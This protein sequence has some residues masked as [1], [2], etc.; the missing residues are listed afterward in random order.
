M[1]LTRNPFNKRSVLV[2]WFVSYVSVLLVPMLISGLI[3]TATWHVVEAEVNRSN[4][5]ILGQTEQ[6]IDNSLLGIERLSIEIALN[7]RVAGFM[8][9]TL[10]LTDSDR[11]DLFNIVNDLR[12]YKVA[13]DYIEQIFVYY[14]NSDTVL[15]TREHMD[16]R[17]LYRSVR[18]SEDKSY[19][20]WKAF[21]DKRYMKEY[22]PMQYGDGEQVE[23]AIV[24]AKSATLDN[25]DQSGA[26]I[27]IVIKDSKLLGS[28]MPAPNASLAILDSQNRLVASKGLV[29]SPAF[30]TY[31]RLVDAKGLFYE[32]DNGN[33]LALSY[34]TSEITGWK[35]VSII[36]AELFDDKMLYLKKLII[37]SLVLCILIGGLVAYIYLRRNYTPISLLIRSFSLKS[38]V[39][40]DEGSNEYL[41][42]QAAL[43][44][45]FD[46]KEKID[47]RLMQHS[48]VIRASFLQGLL[49]GRLDH[50]I[51]LHE[52]LAAHDLRIVSTDF[53]VL[54]F[55]IET[56][57]K[58]QAEGTA[59]PRKIK[60]LHFII[61][62]VA[63]D[64]AGEQHQAF[65]TEMDNMSV[66]IVN[67][68]SQP[69]EI[70][71]K[72]M[73]ER[74]QSFLFDHFHVHLTVSISGIHH[75]LYAIPTAYQE[76]LEAMEYRMVM[77]SGEIIRYAEL[78]IPRA[79][80]EP[81]SYYY[82]LHVE[83]Q[84]INFVKI[85]D[86][87]RSRELI[88]EIIR[89]N[90]GE[91]PISVSFAKC[92]MFDLISTLLKTMSEL[93][94]VDKSKVLEH[95][96]PIE[97]LIGC[98]TIK[99]MQAQIVEVLEQVCSSVA[100]DHRHMHNPLA[101][102][103]I[104][105]VQANFCNSNL[106]ISMIGEA[107]SLTPSY[108]SK[109]FKTYT[110]EALLDYINKTRMEE[111]KKL[112]ALQNLTVTEI[113]GRVGYAD[114]NTFNRIFKKLEGITPGKYKDLQ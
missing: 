34:T 24:Y 99:D 14:K 44:N 86:F 93:H 20:Q 31:D 7:K 52:S 16:S 65:T 49:K 53:A 8:N 35:Y 27:L 72:L 79:S 3:Y 23:K 13:N 95:A 78:P 108:V 15:S 28:M 30:L 69:N 107:F 45:T 40:F 67:F 64:V 33:R 22:V 46:E 100:N 2:T 114:I 29:Q 89:S 80:G 91:I 88:E 43:N 87:E 39:S 5:S 75:D 76:T 32:E 74:V 71:L 102:Q 61:L 6:A 47:S 10:P 83:Q 106:N 82:P 77:G 90:V 92:L 81:G 84:L 36:P 4:E 42:L 98:E 105:Y 104:E 55:H 103:I 97:R 9:T 96:D 37:M 26:V 56:Y 60:L 94:T 110:G 68:A 111:A 50:N 11:Y 73:A 18:G 41:Y 1:G 109:Q 51:P 112:L 59:D 17:T 113:A 54:L 21:F 70:E 25:S 101:G 57:G 48:D 19:E 85:G 58:F 12:V 62:N 38:G 66:C 63:E